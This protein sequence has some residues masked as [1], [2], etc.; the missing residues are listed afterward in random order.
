MPLYRYYFFDIDGEVRDIRA[1]EGRNDSVAVEQAREFLA[2]QN[3]HIAIEIWRGQ[4]FV[5]GVR[6]D[7]STYGRPPKSIRPDKSR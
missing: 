6:R 3:E 7:G 4:G 2:F 5:T 1:A